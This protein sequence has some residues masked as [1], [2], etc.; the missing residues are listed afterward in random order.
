MST[1]NADDPSTWP[2]HI[3]WLQHRTKPHAGEPLETFVAWNLGIGPLVTDDTIDVENAIVRAQHRS[4][5]APLGGRDVVIIDGSPLAGKTFAAL[6][7]ALKQTA[8]AQTGPPPHPTCVHPRPWAYAEVRRQTGAAGVAR[9]L[10]QSVGALVDSK[11]PSLA[12]CV[13]AIRHMT[14]KVGFQGYIVDDVHG[15]LGA[16]SKDSTA[17]ATGL[18]SLITGIPVPAVII[19]ADLKRDGIFQGTA[20]EQVRLSA[21]DW[22]MCGDW[23]TPDGR[24]TTGWERLL[25]ELKDHLAL[26]GGANQFSLRRG[27]L[28][29]LVEGSLGRPGLA[30]RW[31]TSAA[32]YA[33][34]NEATLD[35][36]ALTATYSEIDPAR[37]SLSTEVK[38]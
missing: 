34:A 28:R 6:S 30:I 8:R 3:E 31:V 14:P 23:K 16:G 37:A 1:F 4:R 33:V 36:K 18:K 27:A 19:G 38:A 25:R 13:S 15:M 24:C 22:V 9:S 26:P 35:H 5:R 2:A 21:H 32:N 29:A 20:G 7:V 10:A 11:R 12:D 17:L